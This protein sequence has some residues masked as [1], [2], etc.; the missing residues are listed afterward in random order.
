MNAAQ[1]L[2]VFVVGL[3]GSVHCAGMCGGIVTAMSTVGRGATGRDG[4]VR[5]AVA[6]N[7]VARN[8]VAPAQAGAYAEYPLTRSMGS[9]LRGNDG[10]GCWLITPD[11]FPA[12]CWPARWPVASRA[13]PAT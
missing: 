11:G 9:R 3:A 7:S 8:S 1:L 13:A 2:P 10:G 5:V 6:H 4:A 12:T